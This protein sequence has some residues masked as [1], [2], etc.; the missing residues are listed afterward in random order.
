M[1]LGV[2]GRERELG[3]LV[4][5]VDGGARVALV[6]GGPAAGKAALVG[7]LLRRR[8]ADR[9]VCGRCVGGALPLQPFEQMGMPPPGD[10]ADGP[11]EARRAAQFAH[12]AAW[13]GAR[14]P[15]LVIVE[16]VD[17]ADAALRDLLGWLAL[18]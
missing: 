4:G 1:E 15:Q 3:R 12:V 8:G 9:I 5:L 18:T 14:N 17:L 16:R 10:G 6:V 7:E 2:F 13:L 11:W